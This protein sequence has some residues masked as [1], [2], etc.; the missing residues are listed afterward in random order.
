MQNNLKVSFRLHAQPGVVHVRPVGRSAVPIQPVSRVSFTEWAGLLITTAA[1]RSILLLSEVGSSSV[2]PATAVP[3][4]A[5]P[6]L[7]QVV[8]F[9][10]D[11]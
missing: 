4:L 5:V 9:V 6:K 10:S 11:V 7:E 3:Y 8:T 2:T 1:P